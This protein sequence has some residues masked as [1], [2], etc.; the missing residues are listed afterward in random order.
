MSVFS[1]LTKVLMQAGA[2]K[3]IQGGIK[4]IHRLTRTFGNDVI[5]MSSALL[6]SCEDGHLDV[7]KWLIKRTAADV[8]YN[9]FRTPLSIACEK[10]PFKCC[11]IFSRNCTCR[12]KFTRLST[13]HTSNIRMSSKQRK[14]FQVSN[15]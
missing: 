3:D 10:K 6:K 8:N 1:T 15:V 7:V 5:T 14:C 11:E 12:C 13:L 9:R 4:Y 2:D